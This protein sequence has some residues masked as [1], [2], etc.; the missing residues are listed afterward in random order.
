MSLLEIRDLHVSYPPDVWAVRGLDL[1]VDGGEVVGVVGES[2]SGKSALAHAVL[3]LLPS[4]AR[5]RGSVRL[6]G[7]ELL[8]RSDADLSRVRGREL[9][10]VFQNPLSALTPVRPVGDQIAETIQIHAGAT[11][12]AARARAAELLEMVGIPDAAGR[13]RAYPHEFSGGMRQRVMIAMA[14]ANDPLAIV[15]DEPTTALDVTIQAQ[16]LDVLSV[17]RDATGAAIVLITHDLGVVAGFADRVVVMYAGRAV[18]S[19]RVEDVYARPR[20]P[21]TIGLLRSL[22]RLDEPARALRTAPIEGAPPPS[23]GPPAGCP[24]RP[25]CPLGGPRCDGAEPEAVVVGAGGHRAA[26]VNTALTRDAAGVFPVVPVPVVPP[27]P[28]RTER[29]PVLEVDGLARHFPV[30]RGMVVK[31]RL[32]AVRA[33]DG[34]TLEVRAGE[35]LGLVGESGCGKTTV[36]MEVLRLDRPQR[37]RVHVF[38]QSTA[39]LTAARRKELRRD[40]QVVFQDPFASLDPRM[41]VRDIIAQPLTTHRVARA[42]IPGRVTELL[43]LVGLEDEHAARFPGGLSAGQRQRVAIARALALEPRLLLLDEPVASLDVSVQAG[44][45]ALLEDLR[46]QLG[47]AYVFVAH[48]LAVV[49]RIADRVAVMYNGRIVEIGGADAVYGSPAHPYTRALLDAVPL[50]DPIAERRRRRRPLHGD[51]PDPSAPPRGCR[52]RPR[53]PRYAGLPASARERCEREDP[54]VVARPGAADQAAACHHPLDV[55]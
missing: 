8:G 51:P 11:R 22:P 26:C 41:R 50:P 54:Q 21:Y 43:A 15:A 48:D 7:E 34:V 29:P 20:M 3:G 35:S 38:G 24:F 39:E 4:G 32:G 6:R 1:S 46:A 10:M 2:G 14:I 5:A 47:L 42:R 13:A 40:L 9:A 55:R 36:L 25:R 18:E 44:I 45:M 52:F 31:R 37:G 27:R 53:C 19:G 49:R 33:V 16:I 12:R 23:G 30:Y 28:P 17:A